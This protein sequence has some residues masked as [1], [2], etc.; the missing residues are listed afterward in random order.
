M[1][2]GVRGGPCPAQPISPGGG[3]GANTSLVCGHPV[4]GAGCKRRAGTSTD[5]PHRRR[6]RWRT[7]GKE[8][9]T[10]GR[11]RRSRAAEHVGEDASAKGAMDS[12]G[13]RAAVLARARPARRQPAVPHSGHGRAPNGGAK[14]YGSSTTAPPR[15]G[16]AVAPGGV[17]SSPR[18]GQSG[19]GPASA[20]E[21]V[22]RT[23]V[24]WLLATDAD[25]LAHDHRPLRRERWTASRAPWWPLPAAAV[26]RRGR[27]GAN[28]LLVCG[29]PTPAQAASGGQRSLRSVGQPS[30]SPMWEGTE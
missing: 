23:R 1:R 30:T 8:R 21:A 18:V 5:P 4:S 19:L 29:H 16:G 10:E 14:R 11:S 24:E 25:H 9:G 13:D 2:E 20:V 26:R 15:H 17:R 7:V 6:R 3:V 27:V 22:A 12:G 28:T